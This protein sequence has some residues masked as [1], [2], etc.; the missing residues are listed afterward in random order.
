M[1]DPF[2]P[3]IILAAA[4][5]AGEEKRKM[6]E[7]AQMKKELAEELEFVIDDIIKYR[8]VWPYSEMVEKL[9][10]PIIES[11]LEQCERD[12]VMGWLTYQYEKSLDGGNV[13][14]DFAFR[15]QQLYEDKLAEMEIYLKH[16][17][18]KDE[19]VKKD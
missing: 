5:K 1:I 15:L 7:L 19:S 13:S 3:K 17:G 12:A 4:E 6:I 10:M 18:E 14:D 16:K 11:K 8:G 9:M 2:D